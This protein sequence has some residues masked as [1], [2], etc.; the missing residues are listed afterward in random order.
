MGRPPRIA[1]RG[2]MS[3]IRTLLAGLSTRLAESDPLPPED[4]VALGSTLVLD[5]LY[6]RQGPR[7]ARRIARQAGQQDAE[8]VLHDSFVRMAH[9]QAGRDQAIEHPEAYL[10]AIAA[11]QLRNRAKSALQR[12]LAG[13]IPVEEADLQA[14]DML[15]GLEARDM[16][17]RIQQSLMRLSPR[18][19]EIFLAHRVDG[20]S[21]RD[22]ATRMGL[23][24]KGVEWHMTKAIAHLDRVV[25]SR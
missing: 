2:A 13:S 6:R 15:A 14:P 5:D 9:A 11:N 4:R 20:H 18:T 23:S 19:R 16:I 12:A 25:R 10:D 8:D 7:L 24:V 1:G 3:L 21:Y 17:E 22:I